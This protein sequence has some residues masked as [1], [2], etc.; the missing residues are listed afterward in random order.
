MLQF[1]G[2]LSLGPISP[3]QRRQTHCSKG[4]SSSSTHEPYLSMISQRLDGEIPIPKEN[5]RKL[6]G[7]HAMK[8]T[9]D[10]R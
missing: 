7:V 4:L 8:E 9:V 10:F 2:S 1:G 3:V 6:M 5:N